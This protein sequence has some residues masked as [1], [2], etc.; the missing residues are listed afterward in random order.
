MRTETKIKT[1][2]F[3]VA[4]TRRVKGCA[5]EL[6]NNGE[7][8]GIIT[9]NERSHYI[10]A[11]SSEALASWIKESIYGKRTLVVALPRSL[12]DLIA[13]YRGNNAFEST[14][15][16]P[17]YDDLT[18]TAKSAKRK[19]TLEK[20]RSEPKEIL[21]GLGSVGDFVGGD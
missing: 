5:L 8:I 17:G 7:V 14:H 15:I 2:G 13:R 19:K 4:D 1:T 3:E 9:P 16:N 21:R 10:K 12:T 20:S 6:A 18:A 11:D